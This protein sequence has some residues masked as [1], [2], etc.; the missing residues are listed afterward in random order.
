[1]PKRRSRTGWRAGIHGSA[2]V[3]S[4]GR[5]NRP[6]VGELQADQQIVVGAVALPVL[7]DQHAAQ[8]RQAVD[9]VLADAELVGVGAPGVLDGHRLASPDEFGAGAAEGAPAPLDQGRG[10]PVGGAVPPFH[11]LHAEAVACDPAVRQRQRRRQR[12]GG[13]AGGEGEPLGD[14]ES[15]QVIGESIGRLQR[16]DATVGGSHALTLTMIGRSSQ[17]RPRTVDAC[18]RVGAAASFAAG[19]TMTEDQKYL[20]DINGYIVV[21]NA[22]SAEA[23][24]LANA[25]IDRHA[26]Q[27]RERVG[28]RLPRRRLAGAAGAAPAAA[29]W[30]GRCAG[31][32]RMAAR[33]GTCW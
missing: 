19:P 29:T 8:R 3:W 22:L 9:R 31:K 30:A 6:E 12:S 28:G 17:R 16:S 5:Q 20:F 33:S 2:R 13:I 14:A 4:V 7:A 15:V 23:V 21:R 26:G 1:M 11:R 18:G 10:P 24:A 25:A 32:S 27:I